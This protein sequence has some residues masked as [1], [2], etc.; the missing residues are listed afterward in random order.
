VTI[1]MSRISIVSP[2]TGRIAA[3]SHEPAVEIVGVSRHFGPFTALDNVTL[4]VPKGE[5]VSLLGSSGCG[6]TTLLRIIGGFETPSEGTLR[7]HGRDVTN[8]PPYLRRTNMVF[9][10]LAL[11]PHLNV[12]ENVAFGLEVRKTPKA[13]VRQKV[14]D[15]LDLL[16]LG[17]FRDRRI[18]QLSGGQR[19]RA[20]IGRALVNDP[21]VLLLDEP[22]GALDLQ[23]RLQM[24][25]EL[26]RIQ[27]ALGSTFVFVTH[28]QGEAITMSDRV[29]VMSG[30]RVI[31]YGSP[32]D[33]YE[34]PE[35]RFVAEF[36]GHSNLL[37]GTVLDWNDGYATLACGPLQ[38]TA[39]RK[40][41]L[42]KGAT[43]TVA[44]RY[45]KVIV[46]AFPTPESH[47]GTIA[48]LQYLGPSVRIDVRLDEGGALLSSDVPSTD[49]AGLIVGQTVHLSWARDAA[50]AV[51]D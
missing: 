12:R 10:H 41:Q 44:L 6:K 35:H 39:R 5:F 8:E 20:A 28:D 33:V 16:H 3:S 50:V 47:A 26:R 51:S 22:L 25:V 29:A 2:A 4:T 15:I 42:V 40:A 45:E 17:S 38:V 13:T 49:G 43:A 19:Q 1:A 34:T 32:R 24:Q 27:K 23:L 31:Q 48:D 36:M 14:D 37:P 18:D 46:S 21:E 11:F 9:Q 7:L 30:G